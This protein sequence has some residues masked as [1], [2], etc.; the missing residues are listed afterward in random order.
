MGFALP[1]A[2]GAAIALPG[3]RVLAIAGDGGFQMTAQELG[4]IAQGKLPVKIVVMNNNFLGMVRQ[5]QQLF[6]E[7]RYSFVQMDNPDFVKLADAYGIPARR[8]SKCCEVKDALATMWETPGPYLVEVVCEKE[9][10]IFPM[11]PAG[12]AVADIRLE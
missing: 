10:N 8:V 9:E 12:A 11:I 3:E 7:K 4:T 5:W 2:L 1:A 6:F